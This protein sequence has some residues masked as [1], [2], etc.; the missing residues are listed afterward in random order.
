[1]NARDSFFKSAPAINHWLIN[2]YAESV[3]DAYYN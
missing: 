1:M 3:V 2:R